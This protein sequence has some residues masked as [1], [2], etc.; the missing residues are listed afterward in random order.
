MEQRT[1]EWYEARRGK[2]TA[3]EVYNIMGK[4]RNK[5]SAFSQSGL[6]YLNRKVAEC[7]MP[8][9]AFQAYHERTQVNSAPLRWGIELEPIARSLYSNKMNYEVEEVGFFPCIGY[10]K[11]AGSSPDGW[12][13]KENG[14]IEIK[15]PYTTESH[16][17]HF[18]YQTPE[19]LLAEE[20]QYY[21]QCVMNML[22]TD[23]A[24]CD[25]VSYFP[26]IS[27][28]KQL[29]ILRIPRNEEHI[30]LLRE[31]IGLAVDYMRKQIQLVTTTQ[32][33][34]INERDNKDAA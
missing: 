28:S 8:A 12:L 34:I 33:I 25:F 19:D 22:D 11:F 31:R 16:L 15:C 27:V 13:R 18:M 4:G 30:N 14:I 23:T 32:A 3:S 7:F 9:S 26:D 24:F 17:K 2:I 5:D 6:S 21:W 20:P 1:P 10:E 29:K